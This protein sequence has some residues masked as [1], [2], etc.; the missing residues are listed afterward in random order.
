M[1]AAKS[2]I[3]TRTPALLSNA[4][5]R[6]LILCAWMMYTHG[7]LYQVSWVEDAEVI[8]GVGVS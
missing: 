7:S 3:A 2:S 1:S 8:K 4:P 5:G 6:L